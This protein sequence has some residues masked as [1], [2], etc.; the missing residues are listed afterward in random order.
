[1]LGASTQARFAMNS[2]DRKDPPA[3]PAEPAIPET[4]GNPASNLSPET[5][6][7]DNMSVETAPDGDAASASESVAVLSA[8]F[9]SADV[10]STAG[11]NAGIEQAGASAPEQI[12]P[13]A[14]GKMVI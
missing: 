2:R 14:D 9:G 13:G 1:M 10:E 4:L 12:D 7:A 6:R 8:V 5:K 3:A 11:G